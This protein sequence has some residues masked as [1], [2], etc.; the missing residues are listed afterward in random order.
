LRFWGGNG[1]DNGFKSGKGDIFE[2]FLVLY[3][4][5]RK[6]RISVSL[7]DDVIEEARGGGIWSSVPLTVR[8]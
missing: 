2:D 6:S 7:S 5:R 3:H 4:M 1:L 8:V